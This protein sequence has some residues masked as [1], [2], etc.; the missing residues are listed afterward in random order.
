MIGY[1]NERSLEPYGNWAVAL[2]LFLAAAQELLPI[3]VSLFKDSRFFAEA[4]FKQRFNSLSF[5][6]DQRALILEVAFGKRYF[7]CWTDERLSAEAANYECADPN[8]QLN[9]ETLSEAAERKLVETGEAVSL[10][11]APESIFAQRASLSVSKLSSGQVAQ[12]GNASSIDTVRQWISA[13][14][15]NYDPNSQSAP[16]DFQTILTREPT[17][18]RATGKV[19]RRYSRRV[20]E[21]AG[22]GRL[23]YVDEGHTGHSAHLEVFSAQGEHLGEAEID[24]GDL[25]ERLRVAGRRLKL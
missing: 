16:R 24:T 4:D 12:L 20:F 21:E 8:L 2:A 13:E 19:E 5:P 1:L 6:K 22:T 3:G 14:R 18:F 9:D 23:Y 15:G 11:S 10:L 25:N 17:R 7:K